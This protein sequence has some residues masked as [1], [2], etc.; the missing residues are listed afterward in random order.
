MQQVYLTRCY[1]GIWEKPTLESDIIE[2]NSL[3][4]DC[5]PRSAQLLLPSDSHTTAC[6]LDTSG[7]DAEHL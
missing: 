3:P 2:N 1:N 7:S 6:L 4:A 5:P